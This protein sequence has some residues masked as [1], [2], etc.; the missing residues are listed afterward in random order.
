M[1]KPV[2]KDVGGKEEKAQN[3]DDQT[4]DPGSSVHHVWKSFTEKQLDRVYS[5]SVFANFQELAFQKIGSKLVFFDQDKVYIGDDV[6]PL[7]EG[8]LELLSKKIPDEKLTNEQH[9][10]DYKDILLES[11]AY[12]VQN[13]PSGRLRTSNIPKFRLISELLGMRGA[14]LRPN[15]PKAITD[16]LIAKDNENKYHDVDSSFQSQDDCPM[17]TVGEDDNGMEMDEEDTH[18]D[19]EGDD[20]EDTDKEVSEEK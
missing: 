8:L 12:L 18:K 13:H 4:D 9:L 19:T 16:D 10:K 1:W 11:N 20:D 14:G 6:Y 3:I 5:V 17:N 15:P 7:S 2:I